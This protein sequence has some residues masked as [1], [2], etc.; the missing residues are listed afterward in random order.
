MIDQ[1]AWRFL[2][3]Y[4]IVTAS[5]FE[6]CIHGFLKCVS[7]SA[8]QLIS[9]QNGHEQLSDTSLAIKY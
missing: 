4:T 6:E 1:D 2:T 8:T 3:Q 7:G 9:S 5:N